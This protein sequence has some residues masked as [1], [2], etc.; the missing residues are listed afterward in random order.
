[1]GAG[2]MTLD[3]ED[4]LNYRMIEKNPALYLENREIRTYMR[5]L[6]K[7]ERGRLFG[8]SNWDAVVMAGSTGYLPYYLA[9]EAPAKKKV[10]VDL[11]FL[12][13]VHEKHPARWRRALTVFDRIYAPAHCQQLGSYG[14]ENRLRMMRLPVFAA[15]KPEAGQVE[16]VSYNGED[17]LVCE[18]WKLQGARVSMKLVQKPVPGSILVNG[19][20]PPTEEQKKV[21]EQLE[22]EH[23]LYILGVQSS[24]Y[25]T[26]FPQAVILDEYV[27]GQLYLLPAAWEFFGA[28]DGYAGNPALEYDVTEKICKAFGVKKCLTE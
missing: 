4:F 17:Y 18:K 8:C 16:T 12:P 1:M 6:A 21:L 5:M 24:A 23:R 25:K 22:R 3:E 2:R 15:D 9:A 7:R 28:F 11:D 19:D 13:Y 10:L 20:L 14:Q 27:R 26:I